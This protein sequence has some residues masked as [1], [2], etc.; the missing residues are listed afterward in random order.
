ME[1]LVCFY[2]EIYDYVIQKKS[3]VGLVLLLHNLEY[4][5]LKKIVRNCPRD[6]KFGVV[7]QVVF[8]S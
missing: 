6:W 8:Y 5:F 1:D 4:D 3:T 2:L 7:R